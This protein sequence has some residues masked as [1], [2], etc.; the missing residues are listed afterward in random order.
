MIIK[1][2]WL[3]IILIIF[4]SEV[5]AEQFEYSENLNIFLMS[6]SKNEPGLFG[7]NSICKRDDGF[8]SEVEKSNLLNILRSKKYFTEKV[9]SKDLAVWFVPVS[10]CFSGNRLGSIMIVFDGGEYLKVGDIF[11]SSENIRMS[12]KKIL[13]NEISKVGICSEY[14]YLHTYYKKELSTKE[15]KEIQRCQ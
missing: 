14:H 15:L 8:W 6:V 12:G 2:K 9:M 7:S 4:S 13:F 10:N 3:I 1:C 5:F 11:R